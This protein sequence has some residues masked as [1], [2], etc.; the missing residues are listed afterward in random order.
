M[1]LIR[2]DMIEGR[3]PEEINALLDAIHRALVAAFRIPERDRYQIVHEHPP[4][5]FVVQ[6]TGLSITRT[7]N[8]VVIHVTTRP[9]EREA[10]EN[11]YKIL[12]RELEATCGLAPSDVVVS[13]VTNS[14]ED[15][16]FGY[17][18]AQYLTGELVS[19]SR[20]SLRAAS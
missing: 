4:S 3:S 12:V 16:S 10:K 15:W 19:K 18:R 20:E 17:G 1:P 6:D 13:I 14:D 5:H 11:F 2:V 8:C 9:H 7:A